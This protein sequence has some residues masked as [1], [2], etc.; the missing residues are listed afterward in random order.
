MNINSQDKYD[1]CPQNGCQRN[2]FEKISQNGFGDGN[3]SYAH[4]TAWFNGALYVGTTRCN[5]CMLKFSVSHN[6][7]TAI[8]EM[9][10]WPVE[11]PDTLEGIYELDRRAQIWRY[12]PEIN[13][14]KM[15]Y[16]SPLVSPVKKYMETLKGNDGKER[17]VSTKKDLVPRDIGYRGMCVF[18]GKSDTV[19]A[20]YIASWAP[21][22][23]PGPLILR[24]EDGENFDIVSEYGVI[25]LPITSIR[26]LIEFN[27][28]L[29]MSPTGS[30]GGNANT[31]AIQVVYAS[32]DPA[33]GNWEQTM[34]SGFGDIKNESIFSLGVSKNWLYAGTFNCNGYQIWRTKGGKCAEHD[35]EC[36]VK[37]GAGRGS[38][39]Q[40]ALSICYFKNNLYVG[41]GIQNGGYDRVN[42][43]GP[44]A[45]T[46]IRINEKT[47]KHELIVGA[48][49]EENGDVVTPLSGLTD[50][51]G[52]NFNGY[53]WRMT[54]HKGWL[55]LGTYDASCL[56]EWIEVDELPKLSAEL[57]NYI[58]LDIIKKNRGFE[59]WRSY[60]G[61]NWIPVDR[62]G[63]GC[64]YNNGVRNLVSTPT[65]LFIGT[66]NPFGPKIA[67]EINGNWEYVNNPEGGLEIWMSK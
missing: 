34:V 12:K 26:S 24:T 53:F 25:G 27:G 54:S 9:K 41:S 30:R 66:A 52:N 32:D 21:S 44:A 7:Q 35:W 57:I 62:K 4:S 49:Y 8:N 18:K 15:V 65:G 39:N 13:E 38:T 50:G 11:C 5:M 64:I 17:K 56:I 23:A 6:S 33:K 16:R 46:L 43:I 31:S 22:L 14:W 55:Y 1:P 60:D 48:P 36:V 37:D 2:D 29:Y 67:K 3:N 63:F 47:G 59:L 20:L 61:E 28:K 10:I 45:S 58:G 40:I 42:M 19:E 51:F